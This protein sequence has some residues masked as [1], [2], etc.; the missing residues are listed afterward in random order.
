MAK[1]FTSRSAE[2]REVFW[3]EKISEPKTLIEMQRLLTL[4]QKNHSFIN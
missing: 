3:L 1:A 4:F 2:S